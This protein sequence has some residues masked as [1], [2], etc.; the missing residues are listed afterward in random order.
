MRARFRSWNFEGHWRPKVP[1]KTKLPR[2]VSNAQTY[3]RPDIQ[4]LR[5]LAVCL[6]LAFH[7]GLPL[8]GGFMGVDIFFVISGFVISSLLM[9]QYSTYGQLDLKDFYRRRFWRLIPALSL[10]VTGVCAVSIFVQ[11]PFGDQTATART[12]VGAMLVSANWVIGRYIGDYFSPTAESNPLLNTWS[13]SV[14]EQF[15]ILMPLLV[16]AA[17]IALFR[18]Y[19]L[20]SSALLV[21]TVLSLLSL[22][23]TLLASFGFL[24]V[25][26]DVTPLFYNT[27]ARVW[28]FGAGILLSFLTRSGIAV[29]GKPASLLA[30]F[31]LSCI[32]G[33]V[34]FFP[35][36]SP[37]P[38]LWTVVPVLGTVLLIL[39][40]SGNHVSLPS[41]ALSTAPAAFIGDRSYSIY[42][43]HWP[44]IVFATAIWGYDLG[45]VSLSVLVSVVVALLTYRLVEQ[46]YRHWGT[47][48]GKMVVIAAVFLVATPVAASV[49]LGIGAFL[50]WGSA[51]WKDTR[52]A[53]AI[54]HK[55]CEGDIC[56]IGD[57]ALGRSQRSTV[58]VG[59]SHAWHL[60][61]AVSGVAAQRDQPIV[62]SAENGCPLFD[63]ASIRLELPLLVPESCTLANEFRLD[64][65]LS[66]KK[67][68]LVVI[69]T[70]PGYWGVDPEA[71]RNLEVGI[72][73]A[74]RKLISAE[75]QVILV[76]PI[77][78][79][80]RSATLSANP[81][82][83][84]PWAHFRGSCPGS[85]HVGEIGGASPIARSFFTQLARQTGSRL[86]DLGV[87]Q[88]P[89]EMC[90]PYAN[91]VLVFM[92]ESHISAEL[93]QNATQVFL[94][95]A[96]DELDGTVTE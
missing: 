95:A 42:L 20:G 85:V 96:V 49:S 3:W 24:T 94:E 80:Q 66:L 56:R 25:D 91:D 88:C 53:I 10:L 33:A 32:L 90:G 19:S 67:G 13:L 4:G 78:E 31:G 46:R 64:Q 16:V 58:L 12:G 92:D 34:L 27:F 8:P 82:L 39:S 51:V 75:L 15:Y 62:L 59:D 7:M 83:C 28:E 50:G 72:R 2:P 40:G 63:P 18:R 89:R 79:F 69:G 22:I 71:D 48:H 5:A 77:F 70:S 93:S 9:R 14:E 55:L 68:S 47:S 52:T 86:V 21:T 65:L 74:V 30:W 84:S 54:G 41:R 11:S 57:F 61:E 45:I 76:A 60:S 38:G 6:V 17:Y 29:S 23:F 81:T 26:S 73:A 35:A 37:F 87:I 36:S 1:V 43:W 44:F